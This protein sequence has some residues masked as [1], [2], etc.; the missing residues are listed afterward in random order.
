MRIASVNVTHKAVLHAALAT[1]EK[2]NTC[3]TTASSCDM[4]SA[5]GFDVKLLVLAGRAAGHVEGR[6]S[7]FF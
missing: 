2:R 6:F 1:A 4:A 5:A 7:A 3:L